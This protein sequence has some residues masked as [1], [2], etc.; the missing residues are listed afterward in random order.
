MNK[1]NDLFADAAIT[2][3]SE[4]GVK[5]GTMAQIARQAGVSRQTL[6]TVYASKSEVLIAAIAHD[7]ERRLHTTLAAWKSDKTLADKID[8]F[9]MHDVLPYFRNLFLAL[10]D[11]DS[12][13]MIDIQLQLDGIRDARVSIFADSFKPSAPHL[14][15]HGLSPRTFADFFIRCAD[16]LMQEAR[17]EAQL[18]KLYETLKITTLSVLGQGA[19][20]S[21]RQGAS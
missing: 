14:I 5:H 20:A 16:G 19:S 9:V 15:S 18:T 21:G 7:A 2:I 10:S 6:Y 1:K 8:S 12:E 11:P 13:G 17:D 4:H 3:F